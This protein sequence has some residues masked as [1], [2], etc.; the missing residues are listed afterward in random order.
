[1]TTSVFFHEFSVYLESLVMCNVLLL[2]CDDFNIHMDVP[3]DADTIQL[4]DLLNY[5]G[6]VLSMS[7]DP[8][9]YMATP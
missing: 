9:T 5:M 8:R 7:N 1:M 2:I 3:S 6:L 4:K